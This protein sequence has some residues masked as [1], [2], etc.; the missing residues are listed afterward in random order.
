MYNWRWKII[1]SKFNI[2]NNILNSFED[3]TIP[4]EK[5]YMEIATKLK[6]QVA[7]GSSRFV[8]VCPDDGVVIK[9]PR[10]KSGIRQNHNE[11]NNRNIQN[12]VLVLESHTKYQYEHFILVNKYYKPLEPYIDELIAKLIEHPTKPITNHL[13]HIIT[14]SNIKAHIEQIVYNLYVKQQVRQQTKP[15]AII[16][17]ISTHPI[18]ITIPLDPNDI[19]S[20]LR[21]RIKPQLPAWDHGLKNCGYIDNDIV[22]IDMGINTN[23]D[24]DYNTE[25]FNNPI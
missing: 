24:I 13:N 17:S 21:L 8:Y 19:K 18:S 15:T 10:S 5:E 25:H 7:L 16:S 11:Y 14:M 3:G 20:E 9:L 2:V 23:D 6:L 4:T 22:L 12:H 1:K